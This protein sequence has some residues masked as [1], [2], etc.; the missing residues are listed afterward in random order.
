MFP[1]RMNPKSTRDLYNEALRRFEN[2]DYDTQIKS[3]GSMLIY[4]AQGVSKGEFSNEEA[5]GLYEDFGIKASTLNN[6]YTNV[7]PLI[8]SAH[9]A[10]LKLSLL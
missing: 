1:D 7:N 8:S 9:D 2:G 5:I 10:I 4:I 3:V 6:S